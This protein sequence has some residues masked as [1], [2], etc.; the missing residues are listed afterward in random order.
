[1]ASTEELLTAVLSRPALSLIV[2]PRSEDVYDQF[3]LPNGMKIT[4]THMP[5]SEKAAAAL[6]VQAGAKDD[7]TGA[8]GLA[9]FTEHAVFLGSTTY[10]KENEFKTFLSKNGGSCNGGTGMEQTSYQ[11]QVNKDSFAHALDVWSHFFVDPLFTPEAIS[12]EIM[13]VDAE[14]SKNRIIDGRRMLQVLKDLLVDDSSYKKFSTGNVG[15]LAAGDAEGNS[16]SLTANMRTFYARHYNPGTMTLALVGPQSIDELR[17]LALGM[18]SGVAAKIEDASTPSLSSSSS[19][20]SASSHQTSSSSSYSGVHPFK[21]SVVGTTVR[22]RPIKDVRDLSLYIPLPPT[23]DLHSSSPTRLLSFLL[24]HKGEGSLFA[25]LQDHGWAS[26]TGAGE[27][28]DYPDF[29]IFEVTVA[30]TVEGLRHYK[31]VVAEVWR[32]VRAVQAA[33]DETLLGYWKECKAIGEIDFMYQEK[34]TAYDLAPFLS[35][36]MGLVPLHEILSDGWLLKDLDVPLLRTQFLSRFAPERAVVVLRSKDFSPEVLPEDGD[37]AEKAFLA[38]PTG[39]DTPLGVLGLEPWYKTLY[40]LTEASK[41]E[42]GAWQAALRGTTDSSSSLD[43]Q[44]K[45]ALPPPNVYVCTEADL[46]TSACHSLADKKLRS[47]PPIEVPV[48]AQPQQQPAADAGVRR[49]RAYWSRDEAFAQPRY[50]VHSLVHSCGHSKLASHPINSLIN[51]VFSQSEARFFYPS[52]FAG[53]TWGASVG[54][55]G[56]GITV[57]GFSPKLLTLYEKVSQRF[58][59]MDY[60]RSVDEAIVEVCKER[61]L[62]GMRSWTKDRPDSIADTFL[63]YLLQEEAMLPDE[64]IVL[65]EVMSKA[66]IVETMGQALQR[67][68]ITTYVHG[69]QPAEMAVEVSKAVS[70]LVGADTDME[71]LRRH[72]EERG[73]G[74]P[75]VDRILRARQLPPGHS[76]IHLDSVNP[77]DPNSALVV[78]FQTATRSPATSAINIMLA[79]L[80]R[81]PC[82]NELRTK[83]QLGYIVNTA[84]SGYGTQ[85]GSM[86]GLTFRVLSQRYNPLEMQAALDEFLAA[87]AGVFAALTPSEVSMRC[88]SVVK[89][90]L[91]PP[92][93][94]EEEASQFWGSI[95]EDTPFDWIDQVIA[96]V[97][98]IDVARVQGAFT[99]WVAGQGQGHGGRRSVSVM[100]ESAA[101]KKSR[102]ASSPMSP[103]GAVT[104]MPGLTAFRDA[105]QYVVVEKKDK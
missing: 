22:L 58:G 18:F 104:S 12:R 28:T 21:P 88:E 27:R 19:S 49:L 53:L 103:Q 25:V 47:S 71:A 3:M 26:S 70:R 83:R 91:D 50:V 92:T 9:H 6:T 84:A 100:I 37:A 8:E 68:S 36:Q 76:V 94:Y 14:D 42:M 67:S 16:A 89:S 102:S 44:A 32:H 60:W 5:N 39:K 65:A 56:V 69:D 78:H 101:H 30:L 96:E 38:L 105:L 52:T 48:P 93:T 98:A 35:R 15:T 64:R 79:T 11:F 82:F 77:E 57:S 87:Q 45:H 61:M 72:Q 55:R 99:E 4:I 75:F 29:T 73:W 43:A 80:L 10:P 2:P 31:D 74:M 54:S 97:R 62:R 20:A 46:R 24:S 40:T 86:R 81:E 95:L 17:G 7:P 41:D 59:S 66:M 51:S 85:G 1:M 23:R 33:S 13:A 34:S 90:L 63:N